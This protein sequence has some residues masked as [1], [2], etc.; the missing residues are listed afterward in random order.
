MYI[1]T[2]APTEETTTDFWWMVWQEKT[3]VIVMVTNLVEMGKRKCHKYWPDGWEEYGSLKVSL[4]KEE[5]VADHV[6][7]T[8]VLQQVN[9]AATLL[10]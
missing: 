1:A 8:F 2:Q 5:N 7:R 6:I 4:N 3:T 10:R 9:D